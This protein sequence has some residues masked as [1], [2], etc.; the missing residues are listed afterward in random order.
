MRHRWEQ[1]CSHAIR[2]AVIA[3]AAL[4]AIL[5]DSAGAIVVPAL[6]IA[7]V[8]SGL[9]SGLSGRDL[10][11][12]SAW[13]VAVAVSCAV[14]FFLGQWLVHLE[15]KP[16]LGTL[17]GGS[18]IDEALYLIGFGTVGALV[19]PVVTTQLP[20]W[21]ADGLSVLLTVGIACFVWLAW[22][23]G[24]R[25]ERAPLGYNVGLLV[26]GLV[27]VVGARPYADYYFMVGWTHYI[28]F[29]YAPMAAAF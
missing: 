17:G 9:R 29:L 15:A 28:V 11:R 18:F 20:T 24:S 14:A 5:E 13:P 26:C 21:V 19:A 7:A 2:K 4:A 3:L 12:R 16:L 10:L 8:A 25:K 27:I 6:V 1:G 22:R 23:H